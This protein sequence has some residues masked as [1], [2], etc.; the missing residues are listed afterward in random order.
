[1][2]DQWR[3]LFE[4][5]IEGRRVKPLVKELKKELIQVGF[6]EN[7]AKEIARLAQQTST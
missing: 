6:S 4:G 2:S 7:G 5:D 1:M 3:P